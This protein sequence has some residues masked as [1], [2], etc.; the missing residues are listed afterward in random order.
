MCMCTYSGIAANVRAIKFNYTRFI[1]VPTLAH[2]YVCNRG[3]HAATA[4]HGVKYTNINQLYAPHGSIR[5]F[6]Y[7]IAVIILFYTL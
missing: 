7:V 5:L 3:K 6:T 1:P 4:V 2:P